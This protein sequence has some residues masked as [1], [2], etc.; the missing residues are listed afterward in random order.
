MVKNFIR[1]GRTDGNEEKDVYGRLSAPLRSINR[2][3]IVPE[4]TEIEGN[5]RA[6]SAKLRVA[7][8]I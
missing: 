2:K 1:S 4:E 3:P 6:R 5:T 7:E 8:K